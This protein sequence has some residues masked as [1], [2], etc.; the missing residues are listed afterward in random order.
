MLGH[1]PTCNAHVTV[2][3]HGEHRY[4]DPREGPPVKVILASCSK[5]HK[6]MLLGREEY[7]PDVWSDPWRMYPVERTMLGTAVPETIR[8][9]YREA[10]I[11]FNARAYTASAIMCR[12]VL[13]AT[14]THLGIEDQNLFRALQRLKDDGQIDAQLHEWASE[15]RTMGNKAAHG[16]DLQV[17][18]P[19][20]EDTITFTE[21]IVDYLFVYRQ[22]FNE[23][24]ERRRQGSDNAEEAT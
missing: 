18:R 14:A 4:W 21:A 19:D 12:K 9:A 1:C 10:I 22:R 15:L 13:E 7:G 17:S 24:A 5:C 11:C 23:F 8:I 3:K 6:P 16:V 20:A 2:A